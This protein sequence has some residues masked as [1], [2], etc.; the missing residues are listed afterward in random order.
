MDVLNDAGPQERVKDKHLSELMFRKKHSKDG[1]RV[2]A[3]PFGCRTKDLDDQGYCDC[4]VGFTK[5][6][7]TYEVMRKVN[8]RRH[9]F[10]HEI[11]PILPGDKIM[12]ITSNARVYRAPANYKP[13]A[14]RENPE[15]ES[16][17]EASGQINEPEEPQLVDY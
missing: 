17:L 1:A 3:C 15:F 8:G 2:N 12:R 6:G 7:K 16:F 5:D 10:G 4:L 9:T 11:E 13:Q 14:L